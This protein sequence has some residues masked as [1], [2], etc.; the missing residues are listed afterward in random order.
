MFYVSICQ[1]NDPFLNKI[2][3]NLKSVSQETFD[4]FIKEFWKTDQSFNTFRVSVK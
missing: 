1:N 4:K 3:N 2:F